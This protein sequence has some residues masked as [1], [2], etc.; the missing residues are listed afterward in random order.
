MRAESPPILEGIARLGLGSC[1]HAIGHIAPDDVPSWL[2]SARA[3]VHPSRYESFGLPLIEAMA[4]GAPVASS[5][6]SAIPEICGGGAQLFEP[7]VDAVST[8]LDRLASDGALCAD[9]RAR[10]LARAREF[11]WD[12]AAS[13]TI[14]TYREALGS[15]AR[16]GAAAQ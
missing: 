6:A 5:N 4:C 2:R 8:T 11:T 1:V 9:L 14:A 15:A 3:L 13:E 10:G 12:R 16:E 7:T